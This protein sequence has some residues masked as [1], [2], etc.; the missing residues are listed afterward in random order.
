M[1]EVLWEKCLNEI[2]KKV[3]PNLFKTWFKDL[4]FIS[5]EGNTL[6]LKVKDRIVKEYLEKNYLPL[7][8]E[9]VSKEFG[10]QIEVEL[11]LPEEVSKP[12]QLELN[13]FQGHEKKKN[14]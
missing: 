9:T 2:R 10:R 1:S 13:L 12:L 3:K 4:K 5:L 14:A 8:K 6:K 11:L 7:L